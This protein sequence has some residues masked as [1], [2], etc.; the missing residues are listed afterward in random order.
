MHTTVDTVWQEF[1]RLCQCLFL[2]D[3]IEISAN[4]MSIRSEKRKFTVRMNSSR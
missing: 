2:L 4:N 3:V 1:S